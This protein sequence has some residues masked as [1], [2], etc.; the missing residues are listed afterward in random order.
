MPR[1][2]ERTREIRHTL[3]HL[4]LRVAVR[5]EA[6]TVSSDFMPDCLLIDTTGELRDWYSVATVVFVGKSLT[7]VGGQNPVEP[8][9][10]GK[11]V[12]FGSHMENFAALTKSLLDHHAAI[13][14]IDSNSLANAVA[15]LL[16]GPHARDTL[17][18][19]A[20]RVLAPHRNATLRTAE[21]VL[22]RKPQFLAAN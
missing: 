9:L 11:P 13:Q 12:I 21:L 1:H 15:G 2:V 7:A 4:G 22:S 6:Q 5:Q 3:E 20:A 8:I 14:I 10:A 18:E 19:N 16:R 17:V